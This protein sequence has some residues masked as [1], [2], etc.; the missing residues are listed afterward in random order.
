MKKFFLVIMATLATSFMVEAGTNMN[1]EGSCKGKLHDNTP[2]SFSYYSDFDGCKE[3][4]Q[5][6]I[7]FNK[8]NKALGQ[9]LSTGQRYFTDT[10][11]IYS[12]KDKKLSF[13]NMTGNTSG[14]LTYKDQNGK[15][16]TVTVSC[17]IRNYE[18]AECGQ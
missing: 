10:Q 15:T 2:V 17:E 13:A 16:R 7:T 1:L 11:D 14:K 6:G 4:S 12:F 8:S 3:K 9:I 18:Y 5:A